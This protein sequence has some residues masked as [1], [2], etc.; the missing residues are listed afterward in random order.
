MKLIDDSHIDRL[1]FVPRITLMIVAAGAMIA[2]VGHWY[3]N[4]GLVVCYAWWMWLTILF[5]K[6]IKF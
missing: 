5:F 4:I 2:P 3:Y 1:A 6:Q